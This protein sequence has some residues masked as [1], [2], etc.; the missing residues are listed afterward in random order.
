MTTLREA[1]ERLQVVVEGRSWIGTP[2]HHHGR[3]KGPRGGVDCAQILC[4]VYEACG[5]IPSTD[6]GF[7]AHDHHLH[8]E[9]EIYIEWLERCGAREVEAAGP[10]DVALFRWG[11]TW[12]HGGIVL[13]PG[14]ILHAYLG[15]TVGITRLDEAPLA[16]RSPRFWSLW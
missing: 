11:R 8:R 2:Y 10:G 5:L 6:P 16:G 7:Y 13:E 15:T 1:E 14:V 12:S 9:T 4:A 3:I